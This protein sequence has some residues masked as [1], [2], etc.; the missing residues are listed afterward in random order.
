MGKPWSVS[1]IKRYKGLYKN[2]LKPQGVDNK[3]LSEFSD[4][5]IIELLQFV[6]DNPFER[7]S[8]KVN[9]TLYPRRKTMGYVKTL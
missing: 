7:V 5:R 1:H 2:Y 8:G 4:D 9:T 3:N 6:L